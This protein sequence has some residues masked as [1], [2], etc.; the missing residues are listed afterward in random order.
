MRSR[1]ARSPLRTPSG[2]ALP[3]DVVN[4]SLPG[5]ETTFERTHSYR[6]FVAPGRRSRCRQAQSEMSYG[7]APGFGSLSQKCYAPSAMLTC[8]KLKPNS[9]KLKKALGEISTPGEVMRNWPRRGHRPADS[10]ATRRC[11]LSLF[12]P[13][14]IGKTTVAVAVA[15]PV[16]LSI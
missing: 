15:D 14:G 7:V 16:G 2:C 13:G 8:P 5:P 1:N 10:E 4:E 6:T 11:L 9:K 3:V 12:G